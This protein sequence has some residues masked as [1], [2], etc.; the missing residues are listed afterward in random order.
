MVVYFLQALLR[1]HSEMLK[2][3]LTPA[4]FSQL[5]G[6]VAASLEKDREVVHKLE[7]LLTT[8]VVDESD[9]CAAWT[10]L[11]CEASNTRWHHLCPRSTSMCR[12]DSGTCSLRTVASSK[13]KE[14]QAAIPQE[15]VM[16]VRSSSDYD[17]GVT[18]VTE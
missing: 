18:G 10:Q 16:M 11:S 5:D 13:K 6:T 14:M 12:H 3:I 2:K 1:G 15:L 17:T 8:M 9:Y 4:V 7:T